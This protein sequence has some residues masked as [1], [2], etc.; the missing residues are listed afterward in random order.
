MDDLF[1]EQPDEYP[2]HLVKAI[3]QRLRTSPKKQQDQGFFTEQT[4]QEHQEEKRRK[5]HHH[6]H[7]ESRLPPKFQGSKEEG[8]SDEEDDEDSES[9]FA[10]DDDESDELEII[11]VGR[12]AL[13]PSTS[14]STSVSTS[15]SSSAHRHQHHHHV[16]RQREFALCGAVGSYVYPKRGRNK[17]DRFRFIINAPELRYIQA[18]RIEK[19]RETGSSCR[20]RGGLSFED[21][22]VRTVCRQ[23]YTYRKMLALAE[24]GSEEVDL[25]KFPSCCICYQVEES[26]FSHSSLPI[27]EAKAET[28]EAEVEEAER[29][30]R[31]MRKSSPLTVQDKASTV[32]RLDSSS[33]SGDVDEFSASSSTL[34]RSR[35]RRRRK[36]TTTKSLKTTDY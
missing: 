9:V 24:D 8:V 13:Q 3:V 17:D 15:Q 14:T 33:S 10:F 18:V 35:R 27:K 20:L 28:E 19:C 5:H 1:C 16:H 2:E 31:H 29:V 11:D 30:E 4:P 25:F 32:R 26:L 34:P 12:N 21:F 23:K 7:V 6:Q 22:G 36:R